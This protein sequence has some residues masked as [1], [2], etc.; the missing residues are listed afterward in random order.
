MKH[1]SLYAVLTV[2]L[3]L[4]SCGIETVST[5][6][7][8]DV[9]YTSQASGEK[10]I[11]L[12][13][14]ASRYAGSYFQGYEV[15]YRIYPEQT[16]WTQL[17][18]DIGTL[19]S[20]PLSTLTSMGYKAFSMDSSM[21]AHQVTDS[22]KITSLQDG[23]LITLDFTDFLASGNSGKATPNQPLITVTR[24]GSEIFSKYV[25]RT[26][27]LTGIDSGLQQFS[28]LWTDSTLRSDMQSVVP[29]GS[30]YEL[31]VFIVAYGMTPNIESLLSKPI[32]WGVFYDDITRN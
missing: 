16:V 13:H 5:L 27:A 31:E 25:Y 30:Q 24:S 18:A 26:T 19:S 32:A 20:G 28:Y 1:Y 9:S 17:V 15:Y 21:D 3:A 11:T 8:P 6:A 10:K 12:I 7:A 29:S 2:A 23:D 4:T 22:L 14:S